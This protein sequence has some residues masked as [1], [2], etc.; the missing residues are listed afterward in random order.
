MC[1]FRAKMRLFFI[2]ILLFSM[3][4][5]FS[6]ANAFTIHNT[7]IVSVGSNEKSRALLVTLSFVTSDYNGVNITCSGLS[8]GTIDLTPADGVAPYTYLW[9]NGETTEDLSGLPAGTYTVTVT[10]DIGDVHEHHQYH[11]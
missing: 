11:Q 9:S 4:F 2:Q 10:D 3:Q 8:D 6:D 7:N 5:V 1:D